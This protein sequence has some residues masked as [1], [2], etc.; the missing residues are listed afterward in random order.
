MVKIN[1]E[2]ARRKPETKTVK[3]NIKKFLRDAKDYRVNST[4]RDV[5]S[6]KTGGKGD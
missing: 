5:L 6:S 1:K 3:R 4:H 2:Q